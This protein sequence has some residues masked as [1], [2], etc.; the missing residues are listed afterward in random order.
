[1]IR[2]DA[3]GFFIVIGQRDYENWQIIDRAK[4][5]IREDKTKSAW[6]FHLDNHPSSHVILIFSSDLTEPTVEMI[7]MAA[8]ACKK[9]SKLKNAMNVSVVYGPIGGV[10]KGDS[11]GSVIIVEKLMKRIGDSAYPH[12]PTL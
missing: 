3:N 4:E 5:V 10:K 6:W 2:T 1:M 11:V 7:D 8:A 9:H 12:T